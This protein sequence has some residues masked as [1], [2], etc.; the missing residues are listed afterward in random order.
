V[1]EVVA[2]IILLAL[3]VTLFA[4]IF[5]WV[6]TFPAPPAQNSSQFQA[7]IATGTNSSASCTTAVCKYVVVSIS[8]LHLAGPSVSPYAS[9]Y[10]KSANNPLGPE[11]KTY[12]LTQGGIS[13]G[14]VWSLGQTWYY[15][16]PSGLQPVLPDNITVYVIS[17]NQLLFSIILPGQGFTFPPTFLATSVT[18]GQPSIGQAFTVSASLSGTVTSNS[19]Y[20]SFAGIPGF[21][22][23]SPVA[24]A[25]GGNG[26][27]TLSSSGLGTSTTSGTYYAVFN[28]SNAAG[29]ATTT[30]L[31][32]TIYPASGGSSGPSLT[33]SPSQGPG[34]STVTATGT[35]F[36]ST[37][38]VALTLYG[39]TVTMT[40]CSSGTLSAS[41]T[42][43][44]PTS[45]GGFVCTF[46]ISLTMAAGTYTVFATPLTTGQSASALFTVTTPTLTSPTS[47]SSFAKGNTMTIS[48]TGFS[49]SSTVKA[50]FLYHTSSTA[51]TNAT[52]TCATGSLST[53]ATGTFTCTYTVPNNVYT[54]M[55][56]ATL[57]VEDLSTGRWVTVALTTT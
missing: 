10:L 53:S 2:T 9:I 20:V 55:E 42:S 5:A 12:S 30:A 13:S 54:S 33:L 56:S 1:S 26:V 23:S 22:S 57:S 3:T 4:A 7:S 29:Q 47:G 49:V 41:D 6:N 52:V 35:G 28:A 43:V 32:I 36:S 34:E 14:T 19:V 21:T 40:S 25:L 8:I 37:S 18:P 27:Y 15:P 17:A 44:T 48:G 39:S 51:T 11:F 16:F 46:G 50:Y 31:S 24:M 45:S 38:S